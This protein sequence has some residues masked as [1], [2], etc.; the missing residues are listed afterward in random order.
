[1]K[2][3]FTHKHIINGTAWL[4]YV[5]ISFFNNTMYSILACFALLA[6]CV[7]SIMACKNKECNESS[8][9]NLMKAKAVTMDLLKIFICIILLIV[10]II[11]MLSD[12]IPYID[13]NISLLLSLVAPT[14]LG[15][16][17]ISIGLFFKRYEKESKKTD[18]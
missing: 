15:V 2:V 17:E 6:S 10:V 5:G 16:S 18:A 9:H 14:L 8:A 3:F 4:L 11:E 1:M 12:Y 13:K 7:V